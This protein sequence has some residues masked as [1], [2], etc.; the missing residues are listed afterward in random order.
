MRKPPSSPSS[1]SNSCAPKQTDNMSSMAK[2]H[3]HIKQE[4]SL[5]PPILHT[6][7]ILSAVMREFEDAC[8]GYFDMKE[9]AEDKQV[10]K[11]LA[12]FRDTH[13]KDWI[14]GDHDRIQDLPF[15][16]FMTELRSAYLDD[17]WEEMTHRKLGSMKQGSEPFWD[18]CIRVQAKNSLL[19]GT[20]SYLDNEKL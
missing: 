18:F 15:K 13:I 6:G 9:I 3:A 7:D 2:G 20:P 5:R 14:L 12:S 8:M 16:N 17:D 10:Q 11:I 1:C 19:A 4:T